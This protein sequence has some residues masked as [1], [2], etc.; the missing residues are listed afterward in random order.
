[1]EPASAAS[2]SMAI[3]LTPARAALIAGIFI[4]L[5]VAGLVVDVALLARWSARPVNWRLKAH[6]LSGRPWG[7]GE[8]GLLLLLL[9]GAM[10]V[11]GG[12]TRGLG[13]STA[14]MLQAVVLHG[15][16][17][18]Y[19]V[20]VMRR[21]GWSPRRAFGMRRVVLKADVV[22]GLVVYLAALPL[23]ATYG[24]VGRYLLRRAGMT[25]DR[26]PL[27]DLF[28]VEQGV[29]GRLVLVVLAV[30][31]APL[32]EEMLFRGMGQV[33]LSRAMGMPAAILIV[34]AVFAALHGHVPSM[35]A[36]FVLGIAFSLGYVYTGSLTTALTTHI[37]F[38]AVNLAMVFLM[39]A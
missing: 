12:I 22:A 14:I 38:N 18:G 33:A 9:L 11:T 7:R 10:A 16:A 35:P 13:R 24:A 30:V 19:A 6:R 15:L 20:T 26:Q 5:L 23:A 2:A 17:I 29:G 37:V 1:M 39:R 28:L 31:L 34:A 3:A 27:I 4:G 25:V 36:L 32:A 8:I 21:R